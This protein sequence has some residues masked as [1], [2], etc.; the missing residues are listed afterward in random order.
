[1]ENLKK[2]SELTNTLLRV[3]ENLKEQ[4]HV[5]EF[6]I[7]NTTDGYWDWDLVTNYEYLSPKFKCQ[8]GYSVD[9]LEN[10]PESW[11]KLCNKDDLKLISISIQDTSAVDI[12]KIILN[13]LLPP[14]LW[15]LNSFC[16]SD[17]NDKMINRDNIRQNGIKSR[18]IPLT[19]S[20]TG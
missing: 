16:N 13:I 7:E 5:L 15:T 3:E 10:S 17:G 20:L 6:I 12:K 4:V 19:H 2:L 11:Q 9:E 14:R 8:L 18:D 1:M